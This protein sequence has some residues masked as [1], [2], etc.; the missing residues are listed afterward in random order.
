MHHAWP[1]ARLLH[2]SRSSWS[3]LAHHI[4]GVKADERLE[5]AQVCLSQLIPCYVPLLP[6]DGLAAVQ[7]LKQ[8]PAQVPCLSKA[9]VAC[10]L[11]RC[12]SGS[13]YVASCAM[14][15]EC[16][17]VYRR[18]SPHACRS[19]AKVPQQCCC[20]MRLPICCNTSSRLMTHEKASSYGSCLVAK[21]HLY[22]PLLM[23]GYT[24]SFTE[25]I[26]FFRCSG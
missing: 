14:R 2:R 20:S 13:R 25:S 19:I 5:Q 6:Q 17:Y 8:L 4:D 7:G 3:G 10:R 12:F 26:S 22:T 11:G 1:Q 18:E 16:I 9:S 15:T 24:H 23:V 21:P